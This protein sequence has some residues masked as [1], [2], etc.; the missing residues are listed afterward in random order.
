LPVTKDE[1]SSR[2]SFSATAPTPGLGKF[3]V[4]IKCFAAWEMERHDV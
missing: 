4:H 3:H 1:M 2:F